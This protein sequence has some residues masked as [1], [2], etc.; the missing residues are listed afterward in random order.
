MPRPVGRKKRPQTPLL[1]GPTMNLV[2]RDDKPV[3]TWRKKRPQTAAAR[4][5]RTELMRH[6]HEKSSS[7][8]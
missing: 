3:G 5:D 8:K 1:S 7:H 6:M 4:D 2:I